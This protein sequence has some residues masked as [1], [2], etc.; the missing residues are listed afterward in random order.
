MGLN[1]VLFGFFALVVVSTAF[2]MVMS[3]NSIYSALF[4]A[5]NFATVALLY[6]ILGAPFISLVQVTVYAGS[7]MVLFLFVIMLLGAERLGGGQGMN[8]QRLVA[9]GLGLVLLVEIFAAVVM[10]GGLNQPLAAPS[11]FGSPSDIGMTLYTQYT[12]PFEVTGIILLVAT[13]GAILLTHGETRK[14][15]LEMI[16]KD[17]QAVP[18]GEQ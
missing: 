14:H 9:I 11:N 7:I 12:L 4:L 17:K 1:E 16:K 18:G 2:G 10:R 13:M 15:R 8:R 5:L 6:L 3:R